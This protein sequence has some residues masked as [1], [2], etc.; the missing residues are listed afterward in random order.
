LNTVD[1]IRQTILKN[2]SD[3]LSS[4]SQIARMD[5]NPLFDNINI[6]DKD[7]EN[8]NDT[9][10]KIISQISE[11]LLE[12]FPELNTIKNTLSKKQYF[13]MSIFLI[14][15]LS[16]LYLSILGVVDLLKDENLNSYVINRNNVRVRSEPSTNNSETIIIKLNKNHY[17]EKIDSYKNWIKVEFENENSEV[18]EGW[19]RNDMLKKIE[20]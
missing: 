3:N 13:K 8:I 7:I 16:Q 20:N 18:L 19:I 10:E 15:Y 9:D 17:V 2:N 1:S 14:V 6:S 4:L 5:I 12:L 11:V